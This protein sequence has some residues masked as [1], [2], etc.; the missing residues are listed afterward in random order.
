MLSI[1]IR[2]DSGNGAI[3]MFSRI[4]M[5]LPLY[6]TGVGQGDPCH[7]ADIAE[8]RDGVGSAA[9][10]TRGPSTR[11]STRKRFS[12]RSTRCASSATRSTTRRTSWAC[13]ASRRRI[14]DYRGRAFYA[15]SLS[16]PISPHD[17]RAHGMQLR[18]PLLA[19]RADDIAQRARRQHRTLT[20]GMACAGGA[21]GRGAS[22]EAGIQPEY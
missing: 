19:A 16:A 9:T 8:V 22:C 3:R 1:S 15:I 13:A 21:C 11:S 12:A 17:R 14:P 2:V 18:A 5:R 6:C 20:R 7:M 4:G 10:F